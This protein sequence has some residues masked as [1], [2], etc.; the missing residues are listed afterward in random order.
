MQC[1]S[2]WMFVVSVS[3]EE[4]NLNKGGEFGQE[5]MANGTEWMARC[6]LYLFIPL[7]PPSLPPFSLSLLLNLY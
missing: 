7:F 4:H 3:R 2:E 5:I 6:Y 1:C